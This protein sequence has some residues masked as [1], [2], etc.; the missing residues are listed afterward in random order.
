MFTIFSLVCGDVEG[1]FSKFYSRIDNVNKKSGPFD[2]LFCVG[3][4]FGNS[5]EELL[6]FK[7]KQ[8][9]GNIIEIYQI[10]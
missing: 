7:S 2:Y 10:F 5:D 1:N 8:A 9:K 3:N 6:P 4:F